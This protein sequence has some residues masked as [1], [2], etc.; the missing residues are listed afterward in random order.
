MITRRAHAALLSVCMLAA[1]GPAR[2]ADEAEFLEG[3]AQVDRAMQQGSWER[4]EQDLVALLDAHAER[5]YVLLR[6]NRLEDRLLECAFR[7]A[8]PEPDP[9]TVISGE[10]LSYDAR[11]GKLKLHYDL[12]EMRRRR[13]ERAAQAEAARKAKE[14]EEGRSGGLVQDDDDEEPREMTGAAKVFWDQFTDLFGLMFDADWQYVDGVPVHP[15]VF[16][17]GYTVEVEGVMPDDSGENQLNFVYAQPRMIVRISPTEWF[18]FSFGSMASQSF[19]TRLHTTASAT[20]WLNGKATEVDEYARPLFEPRKNY[21]VKLNVSSSSIT[22]SANG[23]SVLKA[24]KSKDRWGQFGFGRCPGVTG[25]TITGT[26]SPAWLKGKLDAYLSR[27]RRSYSDEHG[28]LQSLPSW[29]AERPRGRE[30][31]ASEHLNDVP[32]PFNP[33]HEKHL[34]ELAELRRKGEFDDAREYL[35]ELE[36][37]KASPEFKLYQTALL[38]LDTRHD[39]AAVEQLDTLLTM[40][41]GFVRGHTLRARAQARR[42]QGDTALAALRDLVEEYPDNVL[43]HETLAEVQLLE[44][45]RDG[46]RA[47]VHA[48]I[49]SGVPAPE[50]RRVQALVESALDGPLWEDYEEADAGSY[51]VR[52]EVESSMATLVARHLEDSLP[53][54]EDLFGV[55]LRRDEVLRVFLFAGAS[56]LADYQRETLGTSRSS[57]GMFSP[58]LD[59]LI[60]ANLPDEDLLRSVLQHEGWHQYLHEIGVDAPA[61][62]VEGVGEYVGAAEEGRRGLEPGKLRTGWIASLNNTKWKWTPLEELLTLDDHSFARKASKLNLEAWALIHTLLKTD[63]PA[64]PAFDALRA[65]LS[66]GVGPAEASQRFLEAVDAEQLLGNVKRHMRELK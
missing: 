38:D 12:A 35:E 31:S 1:A 5:P 19:G 4:A 28:V 22:A 58:E 65:D 42:G 13:E 48:A 17:G 3:L 23:K 25:L 44:G 61:W 16:D 47:T 30:R 52:T 21:S 20:H 9:S 6:Q 8:N 32:G 34:E 40:V 59:Q 39:A 43:A 2:A 26:A 54:Y 36:G 24:K 66:A 10:L 33:S 18:D 57:V 64:R 53:M 15:L 55:P 27:E 41:P 62:F 14:A 49:L 46:A 60:V 37:G 45:D 56:G 29:L 7:A 51:V 63:D 11:S 50:L